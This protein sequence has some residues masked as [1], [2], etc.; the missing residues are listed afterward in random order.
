[1]S[2]EGSRVRVGGSPSAGPG[3]EAGRGDFDGVELA[4]G[5]VAAAGVREGVAGEVVLALG[6][7]VTWRPGR[8]RPSPAWRPASEAETVGFGDFS[9]AGASGSSA[10]ATGAAASS[11]SEAAVIALRVCSPG[12]TG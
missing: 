2:T 11:R 10:W 7:G 1:M 6:E 8:G 4:P 3:G 12:V 5:D 9:G